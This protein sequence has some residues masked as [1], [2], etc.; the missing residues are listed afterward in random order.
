M[1]DADSIIPPELLLPAPRM[2]RRRR[3]ARLAPSVGGW[4]W[5]NRYVSP[6]IVVVFVGLLFCCA[7]ELVLLLRAPLLNG[8]VMR[9]Y[10]TSSS[11]IGVRRSG[12][13]PHVVYRFR[14]PTNAFHEDRQELQSTYGLHPGSAVGVRWITMGSYQTSELDLIRQHWFGER[15]P[16]TVF[17]VLLLFALLL[18]GLG[19]RRARWIISNGIPVVGTVTAAGQVT[20]KHRFFAVRAAYSA[21]TGA[22]TETG[23]AV[24]NQYRVGGRSHERMYEGDPVCV[25]YHPRHPE[26]GVIYNCSP[27]ECVGTEEP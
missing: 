1:V 12:H 4:W 22:E 6:L 2:L 8:T 13:Y 15:G 26:R 9:I 14:D 5:I 19:S 17:G 16:F 25:L 23:A 27:Y 3:L 24:T 18:V 11:S 7:A 21:A 10:Y 20:G